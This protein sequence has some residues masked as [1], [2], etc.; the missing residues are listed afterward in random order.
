MRLF[1]RA[2]EAQAHRPPDS[3]FRG[4]DKDTQVMDA[5]NQVLDP[6]GAPTLEA[7]VD[8]AEAALAKD[9]REAA[10]AGLLAGLER[11]NGGRLALARA[12]PE[13]RT[14]A[15]LEEDQ[16]RLRPLLSR[17]DLLWARLVLTDPRDLHVLEAEVASRLPSG[18]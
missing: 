9:D 1:V 18:K 12:R 10:W 16:R 6:K 11:G 13:A 5:M 7:L 2:L 17:L 3:A 8:E 14:S 4:R 15:S